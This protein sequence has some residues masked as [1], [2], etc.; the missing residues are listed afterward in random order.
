MF[1]CIMA[2]DVNHSP[3]T[4]HQERTSHHSPKKEQS[5]KRYPSCILATC[6]VP[7]DEKGNFLEELFRSEVREVLAHGTRHLYLFGTAG[8]G[9]AVSDRQF[10]RIVRV[11]HEEMQAGKGE[12]MVG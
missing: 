5:M 7:W 8:E 9:Y 6:V 4:T 3:L 1:D 10:E 12:A 2:L 11:F